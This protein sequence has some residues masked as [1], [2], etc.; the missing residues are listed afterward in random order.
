MCK[1]E[2]PTKMPEIK[3]LHQGVYS[4]IREMSHLPIA[5]RE[6]MTHKV[7]E[8]RTIKLNLILK[9]TRTVT[10]F[11]SLFQMAFVAQISLFDQ[12]LQLKKRHA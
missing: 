3:S 10:W 2:G 7:S 5:I 8:G 11:L 4:L 1:A 9:F 6:R 12:C